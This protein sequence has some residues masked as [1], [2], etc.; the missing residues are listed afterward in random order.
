MTD[1]HLKYLTPFDNLKN[2]FVMRSADGEV[3]A[4]A[5]YDDF[6]KFVRSMLLAIEVDETWYRGHNP[7]VDQAIRDGVVSSAKAHFI[8]SGYFEG[9]LPYPI[10]VNEEWYLSTY[11]DIRDAI[12]AGIF[13]SATDHFVRFGYREGRLP[14]KL[15]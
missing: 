4:S 5:K 14:G 7:D 3:W 1:K 11:A 2:L 6:E 10:S 13:S 12:D 8:A 9:R 15:L